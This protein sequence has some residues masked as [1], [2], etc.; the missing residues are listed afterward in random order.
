M[1]RAILARTS[2]EN[3]CVPFLKELTGQTGQMEIEF[4]YS[5][6]LKLFRAMLN[7]RAWPSLITQQ[8]YFFMCG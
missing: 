2:S 3:L 4:R 1:S 6:I 8:F 5:R 7:E